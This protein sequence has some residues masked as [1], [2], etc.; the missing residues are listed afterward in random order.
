MADPG[1]PWAAIVAAS[2]AI[3]A[4]AILI[5][6]PI[7]VR[8]LLAHP[9]D[10]SSHKVATPQGGGL[11]V[12]LALI[13]VCSVT[14]LGL[15]SV[16]AADHPQP[17]TPPGKEKK[18][19]PDKPGK[20]RAIPYKGELKA[21]NQQAKTVTV[22][23]R[24]LQITSETKIKQLDKAALLAD[25]KVGDLVTGQYREV[26]GKLEAVSVYGREP[27][28]AGEKKGKAED[29]KVKPEEKK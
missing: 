3:S 22:G 7:L 5:L 29:K 27:G 21:I 8:H 4:G 18:A 17:A 19:A 28:K 23:E 12:I 15:S 24:T 26:G 9:N 14:T 25:L 20:A 6:R 11:G 13:A 16:D 1:L 10:R 2:A